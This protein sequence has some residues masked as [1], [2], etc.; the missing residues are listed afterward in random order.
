MT[1]CALMP[2]TQS[3]QL[4]AC[5]HLVSRPSQCSSLAILTK[6]WTMGRPGEWFV[7][8]RRLLLYFL[9]C[10]CVWSFPGL[11][12]NFPFHLHTVFPQNAPYF[13][14]RSSASLV[15]GFPHSSFWSLAVS[16]VR[17]YVSVSANWKRWS[18][19]RSESSYKTW[20]LDWTI[21]GLVGWT[22]T[23]MDY[24]EWSGLYGVDHTEWTGSIW[25]WFWTGK[26]NTGRIWPFTPWFQTGVCP[27]QSRS[28]PTWATKIHIVRCK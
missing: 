24:M 15:P 23:G 25:T 14:L 5:L 10:V 20:T 2:A 1:V 13:T 7:I 28:M 8:G 19:T 27:V 21:H 16:S 22:M 3:S 12:Y 17:L 18:W 11:Q 4:L 6:Q 26:Q 9:V